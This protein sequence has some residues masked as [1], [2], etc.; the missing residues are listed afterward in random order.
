[1]NKEGSGLSFDDPT[2]WLIPF[3][4]SLPG[5]GVSR[6]WQLR[7]NNLPLERL[8]TQPLG[9]LQRFFPAACR[10]MFNEFYRYREQSPCWRTFVERHLPLVDTGV[11]VITHEDIRYPEMLM[12]TDQPPP[13]L[14]VQ[15]AVEA[16]S[17]PQIAFVGSRHA[18]PNGRENARQFARYLASVGLGVTSGL[19]QGI[20]AS[21]HLGALEGHGVTLAVMGT[22]IDRIYPA[23]HRTM[24]QDIVAGGG[25][26]ITEFAPGTAPHSGNFPRRNRII[27]GLSLGVVVVEAALKS[28]SLITARYALEQNREVFAIPG[29]IHNPLSRGC[30]RLIREGATLVETAEDI[31]RELRGWALSV[32]MV[33]IGTTAVEGAEPE[34]QADR[35]SDASPQEQALL[36]A[37]GFDV[38]NLDELGARVALSTPELLATLM[39]LELRGLI[40]QE[41]GN[42]VRLG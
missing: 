2:P 16:L 30:H 41:G 40:A 22:G 7:H 21:A 17:M 23:R 33:D 24:A 37:V 35:L 11:D 38:C 29:S 6:Y 19:A 31:A 15:G 1:M 4:L 14:Y 20:D 8:L 18:T 32:P 3:L 28:G 36:K 26:L 42:I 12:A 25:A 10:S 34:S 27:S 13:V 39:Q 9:S 5:F